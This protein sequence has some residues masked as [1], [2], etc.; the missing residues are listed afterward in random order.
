MAYQLYRCRD[1]DTVHALVEESWE[2]ECKIVVARS[3]SFRKCGGVLRKLDANEI[4]GVLTL[5]AA[6]TSPERP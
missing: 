1:C 4:V 3:D 2:D 5:A 6:P